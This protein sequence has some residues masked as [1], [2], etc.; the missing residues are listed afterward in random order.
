MAEHR[1]VI[2]DLRGR[3]IFVDEHLAD[4]LVPLW[5][6]GCETVFSCQG[7]EDEAATIGFVGAEALESAL[8]WL[9]NLII[10]FG[11]VPM[12]RRLQQ[13]SE[14]PGSWGVR[15]W[16]R[17]WFKSGLH[18]CPYKEPPGLMYYE[19]SLPHRDVLV[20]GAWALHRAGLVT[21]RIVMNDAQALSEFVVD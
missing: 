7:D 21:N 1:Q 9:D 6:E 20:L 12:R 15:A 10:E 5:R 11:D 3:D 14:E 2:V 8:I 19:L 18:V 13:R 16:P 4:L 17:M